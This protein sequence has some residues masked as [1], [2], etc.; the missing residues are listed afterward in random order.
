MRQR[1]GDSLKVIVDRDLCEANAICMAACP[2]VFKLDEH[3][4]LKV[5]DEHPPETL[6][7][8]LEDAV[9]RCPRQALS[10]EK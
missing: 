7:T 4:E 10:L 5:L 9:N 6:L 8:K 1:K 2:E 3:D